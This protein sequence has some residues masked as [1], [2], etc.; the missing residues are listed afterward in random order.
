M[1]A[2][3]TLKVVIGMIEKTGS[4]T[5]Q[6]G[7]V[8]GIRKAIATGV[9]ITMTVIMIGHFLGINPTGGRKNRNP[10]ISTEGSQFQRK[11]DKAGLPELR[12]ARKYQ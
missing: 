8:I 4:F 10:K 3:L 7:I 9:G 5:I 11:R 6:V 2:N 12:V 1:I